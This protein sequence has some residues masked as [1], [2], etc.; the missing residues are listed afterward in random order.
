MNAETALKNAKPYKQTNSATS[1]QQGIFSAAE[2]QGREFPPIQWIVPDILPEGLTL[3]A[4]K[5]KLG[6]SWLALDMA[7]AVAGGGS[8]LGRECEHGPVLYLALEDNPRRLQR[9]LRLV[10]GPTSWP[11]DLEFHTE[12]PRLDAGL[13]KMREWVVARPGARLLIVDTL[14]IIRPPSRTA[15]SVHS[16]DYA[17]LR[18]LHQL[19]NKH[20]ISVLV[21][22]H[23]RKADAEDPFDTVSG[24]TGLTGAADSTLILTRRDSD[25]GVIL[26]GRGRDLE[27]FERGLEFDKDSCRWNDV[28][29]PVEAFAS[30]TRQAIFAA[31]RAGK[32]T[33]GSIA[34]AADITDDNARQTLRRMM[35]AGDLTKEARGL[36]HIKTDPLYPCH[37]SHNVTKGS[38]AL[39]KNSVLKA[40][41]SDSADDGCHVVTTAAAESDNVTD[42]TGVQEGAL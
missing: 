36:Y 19:A 7:L 24:S 33:P 3:L 20:A 11:R 23:V 1:I 35:M 28:G 13:A 16:T 6:K 41:E 21:V 5:P 14:A 38:E 26:Y 9:R 22:H 34:E 10:A 31:I 42:V 25:G 18:G 17:A 27:E 32:H 2:L 15:E 4:G 30:D 40:S 37:K 29:N 12:W 8:V 39:E